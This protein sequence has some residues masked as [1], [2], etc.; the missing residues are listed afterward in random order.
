[1]HQSGD[2]SGSL[3]DHSA[4]MDVTRTAF[5][6]WNGG[7]FMHFGQGLD[8]AR[9][10]GSVRR[11]WQAGI[12]TFVTAD[13]YGLGEADKLLGKVLKE[14]PRD[15]YSLVGAVGHDFYAAR[16]DGAKGYPRFTDP[17]LRS[18]AEYRSYVRM[19]VDK[20]LERLGAERF[21][22]LLLHNPDSTGYGSDAVWEA[23]RGVRDE[24]L[25]ERLGVAPGP[26][27]GFTL[28][29]IQ[30]F[31]RF[32]EVIDW[33]MLILSPF[34][35]WPGSLALPAAAVYDIGVMTRV[36]DH[37]GIFHDDVRPG[38]R[39]GPSDHRSF[40][41]PGWVEAGFARLEQLRP[42]IERHQLTPLQFACA[43]NLQQQGVKCV[44]PTL[45]QEVSD[46]SKA[47]EQKVDELAQLPDVRF[48]E[49]ELQQIRSVGDNT[50]CMQLK[51]AN[52]SHDGDPEPD[53]WSVS[54]DLA[55][56]GAR[57]NVNPTADL[58]YRHP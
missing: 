26:A 28:D 53:R 38:H 27:N 3:P 30:C 18:A 7:R 1:M 48:D 42:I 6:S 34:E 50:G 45:I 51:G 33:A 44:V 24:G 32:H 12:R 52:P 54:A 19:A 37:G 15:S 25:T 36:V 10:E 20:S 5:G 23:L 2:A 40:R 49:S 35:P 22:L 11:A 14:F 4:G 16:R 39:F 31:D 57:W 13:V 58:T 46:G 21:D 8:E 9:W 56:T 41:P 47:I 55:A 29:V 17:A 43:W